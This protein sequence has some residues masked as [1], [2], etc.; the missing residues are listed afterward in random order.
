MAVNLNTSI[1]GR[2]S[3]SQLETVTYIAGFD[4]TGVLSDQTF[5]KYFADLNGA[6]RYTDLVGGGVGQSGTVYYTFDTT[7]TSTIQFSAAAKAN[8]AQALQIWS[9]LSNINFIY[10]SDVS[11]VPTNAATLVF[12]RANDTSNLSDVYGG[13]YDVGTSESNLTTT[14]TGTTGVRTV[15]K[16]VI[17]IDDG[18]SFGDIS[19]YT[20]SAGYGISTLVH[21]VGHL[22][23]LGHSGPYNGD[24][25]PAT[26]QNNSTDVR[27]WSVMSYIDATE[28]SAKYYS[29]YDPTGPNVAWSTNS[30]VYAPFTPMGL[31][32][33]AAQREYGAPSNTMFAGGQTFGFNSNV[34]YTAIDGSQQNLSMYDFT[35]NAVPVVTLYDS[36]SN[37]TLDLSGF[38]T[39]STIN[40]NDGTFSSAA[41][42]TGNIFIE[43]GTVINSAIGGAGNDV[44]TV[45]A[46]SDI[47]D[48][49]GG[50]NSVTFADNSASWTLSSDGTTVTAT[51]ASVTD[52]LRN[53]ATLNFADRSIA[54]SSIACFATGTL[55]R[56]N[57]GDVAVE[58]LGAE[59]RCLTRAGYRPILWV[60]HR[61]LQ[62]ASHPR[63]WDVMPIRVRADAFSPGC[64]ARDLLL[65]PDHAVFVQDVLIPVRYLVND[66]T[67]IQEHAD[68]VTYWH[69]ELDAHDVMTAEGLQ[70]ESYLDTGNRDAFENATVTA[71]HPSFGIRDQA[72][73]A[74]HACAPLVEAGDIVDAVRVQLMERAGPLVPAAEVI[75]LDAPGTVNAV[76]PA[77][78]RRVHLVSP[79]A[80]PTGEHRRLGAAIAAI[81]IS[82]T[83]VPLDA[84]CLVSG[85]H[86]V[87]AHWRWTNGEAVVLLKPVGIDTLIE[88]NVA[89]LARSEVAAA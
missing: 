52:T 78:T 11:T 61:R 30:S 84:P 17:Q 23:G 63:P 54:V 74:R 77:G 80:H 4:Q 41:G 36:G 46:N 14:L 35:V 38:T 12:V 51:K 42:L 22:L 1:L 3:S 57:R 76:L 64:P 70:V 89:M 28:T 18:G 59:D 72:S 56:T 68:E 25:T 21:E 5:D 79:C 87:E 7:M 85:F 13:T 19:S 33:I 16:A 48:G 6:T 37:N 43:Y 81:R 66:A 40:L 45:N 47:I 73:W 69:V 88:I 44:I 31:D 58:D 27:T 24:V 71:L 15:K 53:I 9:G 29:S 10:T 2:L 55:I 83:V 67:I 86:E 8:A 26:D 32:I 75:R 49:G 34:K 20:A 60:G 62:C 82:D 65:S 39:V 50:T